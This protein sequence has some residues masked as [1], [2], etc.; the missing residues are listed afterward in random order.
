MRNIRKRG[1]N[2]FSF[3]P[4]SC[5]LQYPTRPVLGR[6][7]RISGNSDEHRNPT[8]EDTKGRGEYKLRSSWLRRSVARYVCFLRG[9]PAIAAAGSGAAGLGLL[10]AQ[11]YGGMA[12]LRKHSHAHKGPSEPSPGPAIH[13]PPSP[14]SARKVR[15]AA[16]SRTDWILGRNNHCRDRLHRHCL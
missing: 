1:L 16:A 8:R 10:S 11:L 9:C 4:S 2:L 13:A 7:A 14:S 12:S 5:P 3:S 15:G 6:K